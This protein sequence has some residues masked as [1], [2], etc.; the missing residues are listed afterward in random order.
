MDDSSKNRVPAEREG[1]DSGVEAAVG[2]PC[3]L[4][5]PIFLLYQ[6]PFHSP[7]GSRASR[8]LQGG[9]APFQLRQRVKEKFREEVGEMESSREPGEGFRVR[10]GMGSQVRLR[11]E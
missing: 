6:L 7:R 4:T 10:E 8:V 1:K 11:N 2:V 3:L 9:A 5:Q